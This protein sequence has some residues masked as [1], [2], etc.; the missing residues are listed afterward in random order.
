M[1]TVGG[2][3]SG[4]DPGHGTSIFPTTTPNR[5]VIDKLENR[6]Q[7]RKQNYFYHLDI[8]IVCETIYIHLYI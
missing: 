6:N 4:E 1:Y 7:K 2:L 8:N 5:L 3:R